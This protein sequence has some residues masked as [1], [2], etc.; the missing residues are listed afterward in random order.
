[1]SKR[2]TSPLPDDPLWYKDAVIYELRVRSFYD[3]DGDGVGDFPGLTAKLDYLADLGVTALWLL[4]FYPS[5]LKDDGYDISDYHDVHPECG[6]LNDFKVFLREAHA[7]GL[8]V[9]TELVVNHTSDQHPWFQRARRAPKGSKERDFY[10]WS[11]T[12][13]RY[14][15]ARIIF[16]DF[17]PSNWSWDP[18]AHS[19]YWHR[20]YAHQPDLN[21]D[22]PAVH[23]AIFQVTDFWFG[24]GVDGLRLDAIPYLYERDGTSCENLPETHTFLRALRAHVDKRWKNRM[25]LAEANQWPED[26]V[27][28]FGDPEVPSGSECHMAFHFPIMPRL[29][30]GVRREDRFPITDIWAQTPSIH[31][32][33]QWALFLRNHD[34][35]TLEMVT[36]EE[37]DYMYRVYAQDT[38]MRINLGIRRRLAPLLGANRRTVE[39]MNG[40]LFSLPGTPV[41]YYGDELGMGDN[42][43]LGDR[44]G[45]RTPMQWSGDR[46]SGF[47]VANPQRLILPVIID[48][49]YHYTTCN[50][51][52]QEQNRHSMLWW[53]RRLIALRRGHRAFGRGSIEF[54]APQNSK[55]LAFVRQFGDERILV[56]ANLSRNVQCA[57]L[58]LSA[59]KGLLPVELFGRTAFP[60]IG[61]APYLLTFAPHAFYW[62][63]LEPPPT[64]A[65]YV[66]VLEAPGRPEP[67]SRRVVSVEALVEE[68]PAE[69]ETRTLCE[70]LLLRYLP[71]C[72]WFL[73]HG[74]ELREVRLREAIALVEQEPQSG[75]GW[76]ILLEAEYADAD[77][78]TY[79][80]GL[81]FQSGEATP[82][83]R[84]RGTVIAQLEDEHGHQAV[85][86]EILG[87]PR[88]ARALL[89]LVDRRRHLRG[90]KGEIDA[91]QATS[92]RAGRDAAAH[93]SAQADPRP[94][95]AEHSNAPMAFGERYLLKV[96]RRLD[97]AVNPE[98]EVLRW[99]S[100]QRHFEHVPRVLGW[101]E[102]GNGQA[103]AARRTLGVLQAF[104]PHQADAWGLTADELKRFYE[105]AV[106]Q[107]GPAP[108][109]P[110]ADLP[111]LLAE[112]PPEPVREIFGSYLGDVE[113]LG[114]RTAELH[115][116]LVGE[117]GDPA[118]GPEPYSM[119][120]QR[121]LYQSMR[122]LVGHHFRQLREGL[123]LL[124]PE[125]AELA[126][127]VLAR[128]PELLG[129]TEFLLQRRLGARRQRCHGHLHLGQVLY[130]GKDFVFI[131]FEGEP[132]RPLSDRRRKRSPL[133]DVAGMIRSFHYAAES[134]LAEQLKGGGLGE[135]T[136]ERVEPLSR[137]WQVWV[138]RAFLKAYLAGACSNGDGR[139]PLVPEDPEELVL[140]L[141]AFLLERAV[142][143]LG[144]ELAHRPGWVRIPLVGIVRLL[145]RSATS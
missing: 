8:R 92:Y 89:E 83:Q 94:M 139:G 97:E 138:D 56:V 47:S 32:S 67:P 99:L 87:D 65:G 63:S 78:E 59:H 51:E 36:D 135:R 1:M 49:E 75:P 42:V 69:G 134:V 72:R 74:R 81:G 136:L 142:Q 132:G 23:R 14:R 4:P 45:V 120:Y 76:V 33:C 43:Y 130:T 24:L 17:E 85:L 80:L 125:V 79:V 64:P 95:H 96:A 124:P 141:R 123:G 98:L 15:E 31:D 128:V 137:L 12:P 119:L 73:G 25:L 50:V 109:L 54:L 38:R 82:E 84:E 111:R 16:K 61:E 10:V 105:A 102:Y 60:R 35:L 77:P 117:E 29:F 6:T 126:Q 112:E 3:S 104:V 57:E 68:S 7:R 39:L 143:E 91:W 2:P 28:Y 11:D 41:L 116:A 103:R 18:V 70:K 62:F 118:F 144:W 30:M 46:N 44:D 108:A 113:L 90:H 140:L 66:Q 48:P 22:N 40:L 115:R 55:V 5:S 21:F 71:G 131:D 9:I 101:L 107:P 52:A 53:M 145:D 88:F 26:A 122:N 133:R 114:R 100:E 121:S 110:P 13:E 86:C 127:S 19:Y 37:R 58:D 93:Q 129:H 106:A 27:A 20:F 34:E